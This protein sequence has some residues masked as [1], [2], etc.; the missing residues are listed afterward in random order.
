MCYILVRFLLI[1]RS[2]VLSAMQMQLSV[3]T[4][5]KEGEKKG[6]KE[7]KKN[8]KKISNVRAVRADLR[9]NNLGVKVMVVQ[10]SSRP[11]ITVGCKEMC[12]FQMRC[13]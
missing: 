8:N 1:T 13:N 12:F 4:M 5:K 6:E 10:F 11:V 7:K 9:V 2:T 3:M